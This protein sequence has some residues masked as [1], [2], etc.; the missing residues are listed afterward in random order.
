MTIIVSCL[1]AVFSL[2]N[3]VA[4]MMISTSEF[5]L[6]SAVLCIY[7]FVHHHSIPYTTLKCQ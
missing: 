3:V 1:R 2:S 7:Y 4:I 6:I 5:H